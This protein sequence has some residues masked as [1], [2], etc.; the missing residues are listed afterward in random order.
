MRSFSNVRISSIVILFTVL[1]CA[2]AN[3]Y[4]LIQYK[5]KD[6]YAKIRC[7]SNQ[8][9]PALLHGI[10]TL[11]G[12][13]L[14]SPIIMLIFCWLTIR[15]IQRIMRKYHIRNLYTLSNGKE[16]KQKF[17]RYQKRLQRSGSTDRQLIRMM[18]VQ[19]IYFSLLSTPVAIYWLYLA[20]E[21]TNT[22]HRY[23]IRR[24]AITELCGQIAGY[25]SVTSACTT[26]CVFTLSSPL[27]R[28]KLKYL[29]HNYLRS[30]QIFV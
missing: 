20:I 10:W 12:F 6:Q 24:T 15:Q 19:C 27:F 2:I 7:P 26:F 11:I 1:I 14:G 4:V 9:S 29:F 22:T 5:I 8:S 18:L 17:E 28:R 30:K 25:L 16:I 23:D 21:T 3:S 13:S